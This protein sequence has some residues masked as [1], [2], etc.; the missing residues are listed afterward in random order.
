VGRHLV[1]ALKVT[2][3][4]VT[5]IDHRLIRGRE[6]PEWGLCESLWEYDDKRIFDVVCHLAIHALDI[7]QRLKPS[8]HAYR[9]LL[10]DYQMCRWIERNP[11][12]QAFVALSTG[13]IDAYEND[14]YAT[15]K[16][17]LERY[18]L[19]LAAQG[20]PV[21]CLRPYAGYGPDQSESLP[22]GAILHRALHR[23]DP[24]TVW[25]SGIAVRDFLY[26][27]D[28]VAAILWAIE[29]VPKPHPQPIDIGTGQWISFKQ[30]AREI[31][32]A[33]GYSPE[34]KPLLDKPESGMYR[35][36][37]TRLATLLGWTA[38]VSL[39]EGIKKCVEANRAAPVQ[40][41]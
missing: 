39:A 18:C 34:I 27:D 25:G 22:F 30:L 4:D 37:D 10:L 20:V 1:P 13:A 40:Q 11:P 6:E 24:L 2:G 5:E 19:R 38:K 21:V 36:A 3:Y 16:W 14:P 32:D 17:M 8:L 28:F 35:V 26:I 15:C 41:R 23:E 9:D 7:E 33:V 31:A 29:S 12:R